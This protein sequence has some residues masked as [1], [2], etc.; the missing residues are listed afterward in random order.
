[1]EQA[2]SLCGGVSL[3]HTMADGK[4]HYEVRNVLAHIR[5]KFVR[6]G[7]KILMI[8]GV[9]T[10]DLPPEEFANML[11]SR[12][13]SL[14]I[15]QA[16]IDTGIKEC[17]EC[18]SIKPYSKEEITLRFRMAM[19][20]EECLEGEENGVDPAMC[21]WE[22]DY[23]END[24]EL[25]LV[26]MNETSVAV[27]SGRGCDPENPCNSCGCHGCNL[28]EV[29]V[30]ADS[31]NVTS[32][33]REY[34]K[35]DHAKQEEMISLVRYHLSNTSF[36]TAPINVYYYTELKQTFIGKPVVLELNEI[37]EF[38]KCTCESQKVVLKSEC[39]DEEKLKKVCKDDKEMLSFVFYMKTL[40]DDTKLFESAAHR[41]WFIETNNHVA[42][43]NR[44]EQ[45]SGSF[46]FV[47]SYKC[48]S[49]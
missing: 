32:V 16:S 5:R 24:Q 21:E 15:H 25:L 14:T 49:Q 10:K 48:T 44:P 28:S 40:K 29:V 11:C 26:S 18:D 38:L 20:R 43:E 35:Y 7:D 22:S 1:M 9:K 31:C 36:L 17:L 4:H 41:G 13:P 6:K 2:S 46:Y 33:G 30:V 34:M 3:L 12:S 47:I 45:I 8:N 42:M 39:C 23:T 19:V 37:N 27:M